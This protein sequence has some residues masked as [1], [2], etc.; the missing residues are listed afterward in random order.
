M[1][2]DVLIDGHVHIYPNFD[3]A[4]FFGAAQRNFGG[5]PGCLLLTETARDDAFAQLGQGASLPSGW[6]LE[7]FADDPAALRLQG[8]AGPILLISGYQVVSEEGIEV[9]TICTTT[10]LPVRLPLDEILTRVGE[11]GC[12][13]ILPWGVG[14]WM[15]RRGKIL[16]DAL[17]R[18]LPK[19]V[20][21]GDNAGRPG[22][23]P[24]PPLFKVAHDAGIAVL[25]GS[26]PLPV[27][28]G[29]LDPG[30]F[31]FR[32]P[33]ALDEHAPAQ[34]LAH[35]L[36]DLSKQPASFGHRTGAVNFVRRQ[37]QLRLK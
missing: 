32:L 36:L 2:D 10:R 23:W 33:G 12:P 29:E 22:L 34:D 8:A 28:G 35:R 30:C 25:P 9:L 27:P 3:L 21:L 14:K 1:T 6:N 13:A 4:A 31:G 11:M 19:G 20:H 17:A 5:R 15:G 37:V 7:R 16:S 26:D 24:E 18:G